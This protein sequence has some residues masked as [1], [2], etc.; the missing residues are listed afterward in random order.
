MRGGLL[1]INGSKVNPKSWRQTQ[2]VVECN[3]DYD[4]AMSGSS[5][6]HDFDSFISPLVLE[7]DETEELKGEVGYILRFK[8][9]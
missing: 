3:D 8:N 9:G 6:D 1:F 2:Q 5:W 7:C 4:D